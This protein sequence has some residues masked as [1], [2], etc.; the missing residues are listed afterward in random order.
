MPISYS[1][2]SPYYGI[3]PVNV[4]TNPNDG[5]GDNLRDSFITTNTNLLSISQFLFTNPLIPQLTVAAAGQGGITANTI[6]A[7]A[8]TSAM[9][10][11]TASSIGTLTVNNATVNG[12]LNLLAPLTANIISTGTSTFNT[13]NA[14]NTVS[15]NIISSGTSVLNIADITTLTVGSSVTWTGTTMTGS[16]AQTPIASVPVATYRSATFTIQAVESLT[17]RFHT[18][19]VLAV[20]DDLNNADSTEFGAI[21]IGGQAAIYTVDVSG[22]NL[23]LLATPSSANSTTFKVHIIAMKA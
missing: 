13:L 21:D 18:A 11:L 17:P 4:G 7:N 1:N 2:G 5:T 3:I 23:R 22:G 10:S 12:T 19:T 16:T 9:S 14:T 6:T 15:S 20:C 8:I